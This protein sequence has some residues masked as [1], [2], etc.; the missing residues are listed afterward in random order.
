MHLRLQEAQAQIGVLEKVQKAAE[1]EVDALLNEFDEAR[2]RLRAIDSQKND[3]QLELLKKRREL[4]SLN[5]E[6]SELNGQMVTL[7]MAKMTE[8][9]KLQDAVD[10]AKAERLEKDYDSKV[11]AIQ[12]AE[13]RCVELEQQLKEIKSESDV[14][15]KRISELEQLKVSEV[16]DLKE[17]LTNLKRNVHEMEQ[18]KEEELNDLVEQVANVTAMYNA[19]L[20]EMAQV[21]E[22]QEEVRELLELKADIQRREH[23]HAVIIEGQ[24][25][26]IEFLDGEY[27][28]E[29]VMRKR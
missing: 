19:N 17:E 29:Q 11:K 6:L 23:E 13:E 14:I 15:S 4:T 10:T 8:I 9:S 21:K 25:K 5:R 3:I 20:E 12:K 28:K 27:K 7:E 18:K 1:A 26:R 22:E 24:G 16:H 2:Q